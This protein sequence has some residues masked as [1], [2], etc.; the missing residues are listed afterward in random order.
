MHKQ[1]I[2]P[3]I[4]KQLYSLCKDNE[5]TIM[6]R[7]FKISLCKFFFSFNLAIYEDQKVSWRIYHYIPFEDKFPIKCV[8]LYIIPQCNKLDQDME[9]EN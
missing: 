6:S 9:L 5:F 3:K 4:I 2:D 1:L 8:E 7:Y